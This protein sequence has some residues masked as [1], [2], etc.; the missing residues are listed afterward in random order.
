MD[1]GTVDINDWQ[2]RASLD[3]ALQ[4]IGKI[5][6]L[7]VRMSRDPRGIWLMLSSAQQ[8]LEDMMGACERT[9]VYDIMKFL[10]N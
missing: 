8:Y 2:Q 9:R 4:E 3:L 10:H 6:K 7:P 1:T 5:I